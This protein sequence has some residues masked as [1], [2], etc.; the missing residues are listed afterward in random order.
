ML[1]SNETGTFIYR[2]CTKFRGINFRALAGSEF[3][4][5][6][7]SCR[8]I[9]VDTRCLRSEMNFQLRS[10]ARNVKFIR[11]STEIG[12]F[13]V[14]I[15]ISCIMVVWEGHQEP[16]QTEQCNE[17]LDRATELAVCMEI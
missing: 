14:A 5:S 6:T 3:R 4:G 2:T 9:F 13:I 16:S 15:G 8:V 1:Y 10:Y 12:L 7:F 17:L 11:I